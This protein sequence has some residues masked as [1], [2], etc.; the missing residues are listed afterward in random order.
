VS[1]PARR[2]SAPGR[3]MNAAPEASR[4]RR[5]SQRTS[6]E[7][8]R[9]TREPWQRGAPRTSRAEPT[10]RGA[11]WAHRASRGG[12]GST[13]PAYQSVPCGTP[14]GSGPHRR[15]ADGPTRR[16]LPPGD[17][18]RAGPPA[19]AARLRRASPG[20]VLTPAGQLGTSDPEERP[21]RGSCPGSGPS[22]RN[23]S[24]GPGHR[25][26]ARD[27]PLA[28]K[29]VRRGLGQIRRRERDARLLGLARL[30]VSTARLLR[31][32]GAIRGQLEPFRKVVNAASA[33]P[34]RHCAT[35]RPA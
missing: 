2:P 27:S 4:E 28:R 19:P 10:E 1:R 11:P 20:R 35:P 18:A 22:C 21:P 9:N 26:R 33:F 31:R 24:P 5:P 8:R 7:S 29:E 25:K 30:D 14:A 34:S 6:G 3:Q 16:R 13:E 17:R 32:L 23:G 12:S 15:R